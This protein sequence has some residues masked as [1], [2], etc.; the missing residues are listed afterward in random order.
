MGW[1]GPGLE[2]RWGEGRWVGWQSPSSPV[3][4]RFIINHSRRAPQTCP[5]L[6][7]SLSSTYKTHSLR[8]WQPTPLPHPLAHSKSPITLAPPQNN[9]F[10]K[11]FVSKFPFPSL[12]TAPPFFAYSLSHPLLSS[13]SSSFCLSLCDKWVLI[14]ADRAMKL[15]E[16]IPGY[17]SGFSLA[18]TYLKQ[19]LNSVARMCLTSPGCHNV[20]KIIIIPWHCIVVIKRNHSHH[21]PH[22]RTQA[23]SSRPCANNDPYKAVYS[24]DPISRY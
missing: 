16:C 3:Y 6:L 17:S 1:L 13:L 24:T 18:L 10:R 2:K 8:W 20:I 12:Y 23:F 21:L 9:K 14:K 19:G 15:K 4:P 22:Q 5:L 7:T 11:V